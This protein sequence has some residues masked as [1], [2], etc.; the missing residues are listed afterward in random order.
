MLKLVALR[1]AT[2]VPTLL[3]ATF[4][5]F[6]LSH[7]GPADPA[8]AFLGEEVTEERLAEV[9]EEFGLN[10]PLIVQYGNWLSDA[11]RGDLGTSVHTFEDVSDTIIRTLPTT[12]QIVV[13]GLILSVLI[14]LPLGVWA[15]TRADTNTDRAISSLSVLGVSIP[16]FWL[17]LILVSALAVNRSW[18]PATGFTS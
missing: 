10:D 11:V 5:V 13:G 4:M 15:A 8:I 6:V 1:A 17:A 9:R 3:L 18:L 2:V 7:L 16:N 14:G 12:V